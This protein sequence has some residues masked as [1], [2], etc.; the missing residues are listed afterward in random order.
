MKTKRGKM[1]P[2]RETE[3]GVTLPETKARQGATDAKKR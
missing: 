2:R 1:A 3:T